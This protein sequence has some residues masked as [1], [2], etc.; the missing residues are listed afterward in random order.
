MECLGR[1]EDQLSWSVSHNWAPKPLEV[2]VRGQMLFLANRKP[3]SIGICDL[4]Q[5][6][7][8]VITQRMEEDTI[9]RQEEL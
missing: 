4:R 8:R 6:W 3:S 2:V 7:P 9:P 1:V 5:S